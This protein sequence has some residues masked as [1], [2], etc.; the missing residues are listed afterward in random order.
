[1][2]LPRHN[3]DLSPHFLSM[4]KAKVWGEDPVTSAEQSSVLNSP[5]GNASPQNTNL[6]PDLSARLH[7][8]R[9]SSHFAC[10]M[11]ARVRSSPQNPKPGNRMTRLQ[12]EIG[13]SHP[14]GETPSPIH[15][16]SVSVTHEP[17]VGVSGMGEIA[18]IQEVI[19]GETKLHTRG[20]CCRM[21]NCP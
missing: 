5:R 11:S 7:P 3:L 13:T 20:V 21:R 10:A 12:P 19:I 14:N 6:V 15:P 2:A 8:A 17:I 18:R 16:G 1:M 9:Q 4:Q